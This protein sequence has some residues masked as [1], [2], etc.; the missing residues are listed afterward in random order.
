M[1]KQTIGIGSAANDGKGDALRDAF[2]KCNDNFDELYSA[3][4]GVLTFK[5]T[6]DC[7]ANPN[8]P[9]ALKGDAYVVSVAGK[10]GGA[11]GTSVE[12]GDMYLAT[13][14]NAGGTQASVGSSWTVLERNLNGA[15]IAANNLGDI[16]N[17][18]TARSN[19][20]LAIGT[21]VQ[22]YD[23]ELAAIAGLTSAANKLPYF[24]GSGTAALTDLIV[25]TPT[26]FTPTVT[27]QSG[28]ITSYTSS[29]SY[30]R[31]GKLIFWSMTVGVTDAGTGS[32]ILY[33]TLPFTAS[34]FSIGDGEEYAAVGFDVRGKVSGRSNSLGIRRLSDGSSVIVTGY[35]VRLNGSF[36][37]S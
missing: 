13:A 27:P 10:I 24:T 4:V 29:G 30:F 33:A 8:Y 25:E 2:D 26:S 14:D 12:A 17:A 21:N 18:A 31:I 19:L 23:A 20:G 34:A 16:A 7:S 28:S 5:G 1:A 22:A 32:G 9:A 35:T 37:A 15:L 11:S 6:T 3:I 36:I